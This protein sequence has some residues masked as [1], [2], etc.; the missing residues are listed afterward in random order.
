MIPGDPQRVRDFVYVDDVVAAL[1]AIAVQGR[2]GE[3]LTLASGRPTP[4]L[5][6]A[7]LVREAAGA[8]SRSRRRAASSRPARTA[9]IRRTATW[10]V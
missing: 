8:A 3:T 6:A 4:L 9:A 7:E 10:R 1:E 2:W 5:R